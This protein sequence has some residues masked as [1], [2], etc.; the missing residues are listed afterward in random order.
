MLIIELMPV[1]TEPE[2]HGTYT[3]LPTRTMDR[4][5]QSVAVPRLRAAF[6]SRCDLSSQPLNDSIIFG[7]RSDPKPSYLIA[8]DYADG[9][10]I[11]AYAN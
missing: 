9:A 5:S 4:E 10:I 8:F 2:F 11:Y 1:K 7:M 6:L 3:L